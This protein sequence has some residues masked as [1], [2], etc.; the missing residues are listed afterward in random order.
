LAG[1]ASSDPSE[2][3]EIQ[4]RI[5]RGDGSN[6]TI[7]YLPGL[8]GDWTLLAPFR[9]ALAGR[10]RLVEFAYPR[11][12]DWKL[13]DYASAVEAALNS[14]GISQAWLLGE[15]FSSQIAWQLLANQAPRHEHRALK[16]EGLILAGGFVRHP[17]PWGV[18]L[19]HRISATV[20]MGFLK[21]ACRLYGKI[22]GRRAC[23]CPDLA[24]DLQ[25]FVARR[26]QE[27]DRAAITAR[28]KVIT[29]NDVRPM[30]RQCQVPV[31][32][33]SGGI[34]P[35][36]PWWQVRPWLRRHCPGYRASWI[37]PRAGHNVLMSAPQESARQ[38]LD[39][40]G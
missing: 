37:I 32:H 31:F 21:C 27:A 24:T 12:T 25:E 30:A 13:R 19:A 8:H 5:H 2:P 40:I 20:P 9:A 3:E 14:Q 6:P 39:W 16:F 33:L 4:V 26:T 35:I 23:D 1:R 10:A 38:I 11:R 29:E 34:D 18:R 7:V 36:V 28:Y 17:W 15:S 22:A